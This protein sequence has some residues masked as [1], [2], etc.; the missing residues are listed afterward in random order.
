VAAPVSTID[1]GTPDGAAIP[2]EE[3]DPGEV[4]EGGEAF[5]PA[6]DVTPAELVTAI[7]T[8]AGV[9]RPPHPEAIA[10]ALLVATARELL[11][12]GLVTGTAGN[13]S[14][15]HGDGM[16]ITPAALPYEEMTADDVVAVGRGGEAEPGQREPSSE[17]RVHAAIYAAR[18]DVAAI[19]H[20]HSPRATEWSH[21]DRPLAGAPTT[22]YAPTGTGEIAAAAVDALGAGDAILLARHGVVGVGASLAA[23]LATCVAVERRASVSDFT[24]V[25][26]GE[27]HTYE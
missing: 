14:T 3:R 16:L 19:V 22:R 17:W 10:R 11:R 5:N 26:E 15:R 9:L 2:I 24:Q 27:A 18:P 21:L 7:V 12:R 4:L 6:F 20:T 1:P 8:E 25:P 23:A 13:V